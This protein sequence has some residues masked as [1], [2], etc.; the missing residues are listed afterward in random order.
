MEVACCRSVLEVSSLGRASLPECRYRQFKR[1]INAKAVL[2]D[3]LSHIMQTHVTMVWRYQ[4]R[5]DCLLYSLTS[6]MALS[7]LSLSFV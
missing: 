6:T 2:G 3:I 7:L 5:L 1:D 4:S